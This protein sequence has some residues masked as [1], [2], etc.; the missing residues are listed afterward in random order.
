MKSPWNGELVELEASPAARGHCLRSHLTPLCFH[1]VEL[2]CKVENKI[3]IDE[4]AGSSKGDNAVIYETK[5]NTR[6]SSQ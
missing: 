1:S 2:K 4:L 3:L 6:L 5:N